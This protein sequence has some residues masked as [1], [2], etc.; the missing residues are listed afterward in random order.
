M[1]SGSGLIHHECGAWHNLKGITCGYSWSNDCLV[2]VRHTQGVDFQIFGFDF[3]IA[4]ESFPS[5]LAAGVFD[6]PVSYSGRP[7]AVKWYKAN[8]GRGVGFSLGDYSAS[9]G[10]GKL[11]AR[12]CLTFTDSSSG[13]GN[14]HV[15]LRKGDTAIVSAG[16]P[17]NG[18]AKNLKACIGECDNDGQCAKGLKCFQRSNGERIPGCAGNGSGNDWD[19]CYDPNWEKNNIYLNDNFGNSYSGS[20]L[21]H[22]EC[23][24]WVDASKIKCGYSWSNTCQVDVRHSQGVNLV[25]YDYDIEVASSTTSKVPVYL[26]RFDVAAQYS[27]KPWA[28]GWYKIN[29]KTGIGFTVNDYPGANRVRLCATFTDSS[30][31][32]GNVYLR[33]RN[34]ADTK[35]SGSNN[36]GAKNLKACTGECDAD[37]QCAKGLKCYQRSHGDHIPGCSGNGSGKDWDYCYDP[38]VVYLSDNLGNTYSGSGLIHHECGNWHDVKKVKCGY[39]WSNDCQIDVK[40]SQGVSLTIYDV[41]V[42]FTKV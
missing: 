39:S 6:V 7:S 5:P 10:N 27:G 12:G 41:D 17:N 15:Q 8:T 19:Y 37:S 14:V 35:L 20:G 9:K 4:T 13:K 32:K 31:G 16:G 21:I 11:Y 22:H 18:N 30:T 36:A 33:L 2:N 25:I 28:L 26:G 34:A 23:G 38:N 1:G 42:E 3:E 24:T 29:S 40:H